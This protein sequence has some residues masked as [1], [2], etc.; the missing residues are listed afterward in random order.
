MKN[1]TI[2]SLILAYT[3]VNEQQGN[4][5]FFVHGNSASAQNWHKQLSD[6]NFGNYR[7]IAFD[8]PAHGQSA[9]S[10]NPDEDYSLTGM[11][12]I[13]ATAV[14]ELSLNKPFILVGVSLGTSVVAEMLPY[15]NPAGIIILGCNVLGGKYTMQQ[16]FKPGLDSTTL[17]ADAATP[18]SIAKF[19]YDATFLKLP[20]DTDLILNDYQSVKPGFRPTLLKTFMQGKISNEIELLQKTNMP[21]AVIFGAEDNF[22]NN[23]YLDDMPFKTWQNTAFKI[24]QAGHYAQLDQPDAFNSLVLAYATEVFK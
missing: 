19:A 6:P 16:A 13:L 17:F 18:D 5:L 20:A 21:I 22:C 2:N 4:T 14:N 9:A 7:L 10:V 1:I 24:P 12:K 3:E 15:L 8:L 23:T 11:G